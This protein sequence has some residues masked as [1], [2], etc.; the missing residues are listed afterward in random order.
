MSF[1]ACGQYLFGCHPGA[2]PT[3]PSLQETI[4]GRL[5]ASPVLRM[6]RDQVGDGLAM[7]RDGNGLAVFDIPKEFSQACL[8]FSRLKLAHNVASNLSF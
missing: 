8:G 5:T 4:Y 6:G 1:V 7:P 3:S 2:F